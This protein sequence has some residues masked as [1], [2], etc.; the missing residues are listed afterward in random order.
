VTVD[1]SMIEKN[2]FFLYCLIMEIQNVL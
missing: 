1:K 2:F